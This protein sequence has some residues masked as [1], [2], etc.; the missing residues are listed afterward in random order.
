MYS[1]LRS[2]IGGVYFW[3]LSSVTAPDE[4]ERMQR[5]ADFAFRQAFA[6]CPSSIEAIFRYVS[7]LIGQKRVPDALILVQTAAKVD[8]TNPQLPSLIQQLRLVKERPSR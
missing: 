8:P 6:F 3:R 4:K 2:S 1:K 5:E 7:V